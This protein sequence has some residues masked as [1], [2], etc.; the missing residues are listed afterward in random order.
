MGLFDYIKRKLK[1]E[2]QPELSVS[3]K[4]RKRA[5][6]GVAF[7][8][9]GTRGFAHIGVIR[10]FEENGISFDCVSGCSVGSIVAA[11]Y[12]CG[13]DSRQMERIASEI[14]YSD[15]KNSRL[16]FMPSDSGNI[17][18]VVRRAIGDVRFEDLRSPLAVNATDLISGEEIVLREGDVAKA[19]SASCAVPGIFTPVETDGYR[20]VDGGLINPVPA[21]LCRMQGAEVVVSVDIHSQRGEGTDSEKMLDVLKASFRIAMKSTAVKGILNSDLIVQPDCQRYDQTKLEHMREMIDEGYRAAMAKMDEIK[22]L[23]GYETEKTLAKSRRPSE[24][25]GDAPRE[26]EKQPTVVG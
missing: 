10:A 16:F 8:G 22:L 12:C 3:A 20:L 17:E 15:I 24:K 14:K 18:A 5:K 21:E 11:L 9:G 23:L 26:E 19:V 7:G 6:A 25:N 4:N 13:L 1:R 2:P